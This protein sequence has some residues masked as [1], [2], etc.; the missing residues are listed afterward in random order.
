MNSLETEILNVHAE[1]TSR[2]ELSVSLAEIFNIEDSEGLLDRKRFFIYVKK[3]C[4]RRSLDALRLQKYFVENNWEPVSN[5]SDAD[6]IF[7]YTCG[8]FDHYEKLSILSVE[9]ALENKSAK[10]IVTGCLPKAN[11]ESL[12]KFKTDC[13]VLAE[14]LNLFS[15]IPANSSFGELNGFSRTQGIDDLHRGSLLR[16]LT[17]KKVLDFI[18]YSVGKL[19]YSPNKQVWAQDVFF[20]KSTYRLEIARGCLGNCSYCAIKMGLPKFKS[21][22]EEDIVKEFQSGLRKNFKTFALLAGDIGCYGFDIDTNLPSLLS[23]L[24]EVEGDYKILLWDFNVRWFIKYRLQLLSVLKENF[25]KVE[26]I[27][28]PI[29]SGSNRILKLMNRHYTIE[30]V[31]DCILNLQKS[32]P[33]L[34]LETHIMV[35][36]PGETDEDFGKTLD[37]VK[38]IDFDDIAIF[39]Y[40]DRPGTEASEMQDKVPEDVIKRRKK[41][42]R[43]EFE[44]KKKR[45]RI[46]P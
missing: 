28:L 35:G 2:S 26:R 23:R 40:E 7:V 8:C 32:I 43:E 10:V 25:K 20:S 4:P 33:E 34:V 6:L 24:F 9:K 45:V 1:E 38:E 18:R 30:E 36:F 5:P 29:Q 44:R 21:R 37:L 3:T 13:L 11:P 12:D 16:R 15:S 42:L 22:P 39:T 46:I 14:D 31:K 41:I 19:H 17:F 27:I